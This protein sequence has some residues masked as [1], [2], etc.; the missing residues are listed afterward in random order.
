MHAC[1]WGI[2]ESFSPLDVGSFFSLLYQTPLSGGYLID[3]AAR[4]FEEGLQ[5]DTIFMIQ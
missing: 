4:L 2:A 3:S 5:S 1:M